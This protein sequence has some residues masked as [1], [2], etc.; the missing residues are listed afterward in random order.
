MRVAFWV[1]PEADFEA[2]CEL[3]GSPQVA[4]YQ[5][6]MTLLAAIQADQEQQGQEV[7]R[8]PMT[9]THMRRELEEM[10]LANTPDNRAAIV[11]LRA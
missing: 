5:G 8:V 3:V 10:G 4:D 7:V 6:Y 11:G 1:F 9:V 2:W